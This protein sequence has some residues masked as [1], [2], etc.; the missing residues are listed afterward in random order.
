MNLENEIGALLFQ[1]GMSSDVT[2]RIQG[3]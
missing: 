1:R 2:S 3:I